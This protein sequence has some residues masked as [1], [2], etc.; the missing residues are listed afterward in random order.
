[1]RIVTLACAGIALLV[2][3]VPA[4][5]L[6]LNEVDTETPTDMVNALLAGSSGITL[7][8]APTF[9]GRTGGAVPNT[10]FFYAPQSA[11]YTGFNTV[12]FAHPDGILLTTGIGNVPTTNSYT[13][14]SWAVTATLVPPGTGSDSDLAAITGATINSKNILE[15]TFTV[16]TGITSIEAEF[17][18]GTEEYPESFAAVT[19]NRGF[20]DVFGFFVDGTNYAYLAGTTPVETTPANSA[21]FNNNDFQGGT[22]PYA[23]E[24]DGLTNSI[25]IVGMLDP[26]LTEHTLKI[27]IGDGGDNLFNSGVFIGNL[28]ATN[29]TPDDPVV[30]EPSSIALLGLGLA[31]LGLVVRKRRRTA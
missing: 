2:L 13:N 24:Y 21:Y 29:F 3:C 31:G 1:M 9:V 22:P 11:I 10:D 19:G 12:G 16:P 27:A 23:I 6:S 25:H 18:F 30:P 4:S 26:D 14:F 8:G 17:V 5:A 20:I 7:V 15:F 28:R